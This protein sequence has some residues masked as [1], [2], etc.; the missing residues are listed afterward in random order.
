MRHVFVMYYYWVSFAI[1]AGALIALIVYACD[2]RAIKK[3]SLEQAE[4]AQ[5]PC[6]VL[7]TESRDYD[8][9][10]VQAD[11]AMGGA[12]IARRNRVAL[13][14][15]GNGP[16]LNVRYDFRPRD[17]S[18]ISRP[19]GYLPEIIAGRSLELAVPRSIFDTDDYEA[20]L[21]YES[22]SRQKYESSIVVTRGVV[23]EFHG[24]TKLGISA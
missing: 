19:R 8:E 15:V 5:K 23:T 2:T 9:T 14:N 18:N 16:A 24:P 11:G 17:P 20:V 10:A 12:V 21:Q 13:E 6:L 7:V 3:A 1:Q 22:M 4:A